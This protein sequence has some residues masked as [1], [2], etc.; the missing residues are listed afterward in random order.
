MASE[1]A[2]PLSPKKKFHWKEG[3][4]SL[5]ESIHN[6]K[7]LDLTMAHKHEDDSVSSD[8]DADSIDEVIEVEESETGIEEDDASYEE[9]EEVVEEEEEVEETEADDEDADMEEASVQRHQEKEEKDVSQFSD[10]KVSN[11]P[12]SESEEQEPEH[13]P[14][15]QHE[16]YQPKQQTNYSSPSVPAYNSSNDDDNENK[17]LSWEKPA[18]TKTQVLRNTNKGK[19]VKEGNTLSV[20]ITKIADVAAD[21]KDLSFKKPDWTKNMKLRS[22]GKGEVLKT[23]GNLAKPITSLPHM[24]KQFDKVEPTMLEK[25]HSPARSEPKPTYTSSSNNCTSNTDAEMDDRKIEWAKPDWTKKPVLKGT[26]KGDKLKSG[27]TLSRPI[28]G[29]KPVDD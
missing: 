14:V 23:E 19:G 7:P 17:Q 3:K 15:R 6:I 4:E 21:N 11:E 9:V 29:I 1:C 27:A 20:P 8:P 2:G 24:G 13:E 10:M 16:E 28:G 5:E 25:S 12:E 26:A 22:T 18:W